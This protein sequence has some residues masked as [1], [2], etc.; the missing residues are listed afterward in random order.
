LLT[1]ARLSLPFCATR[2]P[3]FAFV[4]FADFDILRTCRFSIITTAWFLLMSFET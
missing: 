2:F 3:G 1:L 4:P